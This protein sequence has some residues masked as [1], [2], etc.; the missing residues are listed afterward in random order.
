MQAINISRNIPG[1]VQPL[2]SGDFAI[3][4]KVAISGM[5][6]ASVSPDAGPSLVLSD[7]NI[8]GSGNQ[9]VGYNS[10][11]GEHPAWVGVQG[12]TGFNT[13]RAGYTQNFYSAG[14]RYIAFRRSGTAYS[15]GWSQDGKNFTWAAFTPNFTPIYFGV[16]IAC[17]QNAR[18]DGSFEFIRY[19]PNATAKL[20]GVRTV[21]GGGGGGSEGTTW[22]FWDPDYMSSATTTQDDEFSG[23]SLDSKWT[24]INWS[25]LST[26][27]IENDRLKLA[28]TGSQ[29][30]N[31]MGVMQPLPSGDFTIVEKISAFSATGN[32]FPGLALSDGVTV[33]SG[34]QLLIFW[35]R[36]DGAV[37][38]YTWSGFNSLG[39]AVA[40][41]SSSLCP[42]YFKIVR[43][44]TVCTFFFSMDGEQWVQVGGNITPSFTPAYMGM[45]TGCYSGVFVQSIDYFVYRGSSTA[46]FGGIRSVGGNVINSN[47]IL[48]YGPDIPPTVPNVWDDEFTS[49]TGPSGSGAWSW[50][51]QGSASYR[52]Q[53]GALAITAPATA[54]D[55]LRC[56][57]KSFD[58][59]GAWTLT[60]KVKHQSTHTT[61]PQGVGII[62]RNSSTGKLLTINIAYGDRP[63]DS[64]YQFNA[65]GTK[66]NSTSS[67]NAAIGSVFIATPCAYLQ[68]VCNGTDLKF[69]VSSDGE[70]FT[71]FASTTLADFISSIDQ[72]GV[73]SNTC[74]AKADLDGVF[75]WIRK[76]WTANSYSISTID[77]FSTVETLTNKV[78][79]G[80]KVYRKVVDCGYLPNANIITV[81]HGISGN[82]T[83][84]DVHGVAT[85][86]SNT[87]VNVPYGNPQTSESIGLWV[88]TSVIS[89]RTGSN[90]SSFYCYAVVEYTKD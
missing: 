33:G 43:S 19:Y 90:R 6:G 10:F 48:A 9:A 66:W 68:V 70:V 88:D 14:V 21:G 28:V 56:L 73:F 49:D 53:N 74:T 1:I 16:V 58:G 44:G 77:E 34:S 5:G 59:S 76:D 36:Q 51:N 7:S 63:D 78:W 62:F 35:S 61:F 60:A 12:W 72:V 52:I 23:T 84:V 67:Y 20:G 8:L 54:Y 42:K 26:K 81:A 13:I 38:V 17:N 80:K 37:Y 15:F 75:S 47:A 24:T 83:V 40:S 2:P 29:S 45:L 86:G 82:F 89:I 39:G 85:W 69:A 79:L 65:Y 71:T 4:T 31:T 87:G 55:Q 25:L 27:S 32:S 22:S 50:L 18:I 57:V 3:Y 41:F 46:A 11:V 30:W 64:R